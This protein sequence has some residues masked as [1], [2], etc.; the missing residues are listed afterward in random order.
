MKQLNQ[1]AQVMHTKINQKY[2]EIQLELDQLHENIETNREHWKKS[3]ANRMEMKIGCVLM[4]QSEKDEA[5]GFEFNKARD[6]F[7]RVKEL[8]HFFNSQ[9][10]ISLSN[11]E[12]N[13]MY[14]NTLHLVFP[15][16]TVDGFNLMENFSIENTIQTMEYSDQQSIDMDENT[17]YRRSTG[18]YHS[19]L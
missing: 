5:D 12:D 10:L 7:V 3:L 6:E 17:N 8:F 14:L 19:Y 16:V 4:E 1:W 13:Q 2:K 15:N 18:N 11:I 9:P